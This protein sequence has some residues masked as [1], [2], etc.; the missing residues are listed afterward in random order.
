[1]SIKLVSLNIE[2][3][4][5]YEKIIPFIKKQNPDVVCFQEVLEEDFEL[6]KN[7]LG[8][9]GYFMPW[10]Y[11]D[12]TD[13]H[14]AEIYGKR[15]GSAVFSPSISAHGH[16]YF[17]GSK[18]CIDIPFSD[19]DKKNESQKCYALVWVDIDA[20]DGELYRL[21]TTHFPATVKGESSPHQLEI[22]APFFKHIETL[23]E[24][25]LCGDFNAPRGNETFTRLTE[26][27]KDCIPQSY[28]TSID[29]NLHRNGNE[30]I[31]FM[32]DGL[33]LTQAYT[34]TDVSLKDGVSDHMAIVATLHKNKF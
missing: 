33:F 1:M 5:H 24:F 21:I 7:E 3:N 34:A 4:K 10:R 30:N 8:Y 28:M 32:V 9:D 26:R 17:W 2:C 29:N 16:H 27:Y 23:G 22:L 11:F 12:S 18:E 20:G 13:D 6:L 25:V 15:F 19:F 14:H 31:M